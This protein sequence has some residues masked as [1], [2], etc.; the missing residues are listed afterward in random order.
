[1]KNIFELFEDE[2]ELLGNL[3]EFSFYGDIATY[4]DQDNFSHYNNC[5]S[6]RT[7]PKTV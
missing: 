5:L 4:V 7:L 1:M 2:F 6:P 3:Q